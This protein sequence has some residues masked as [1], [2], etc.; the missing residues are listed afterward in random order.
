MHPTVSVTTDFDAVLRDR[1][2]DAVAVATPLATHYALARA[3]LQAGKHVLVEKTFTFSLE[4]AENLIRLARQKGRILM[5]GQTY[6][7]SP[8][9][10]KIKEMIDQAS[11]GKIH[12]INST[13]VHFGHL[14]PNESVIWDLASHDLSMVFFWLERYRYRVSCSGKDG[15]KRG[16]VDTADI[17]LEFLDGGPLVN[18]FVSWLAPIKMRN[19]IITG[20]KKMIFFNDTRNDEKLKV[21]DQRAVKKE[22]EWSTRAGHVHSPSLEVCEPLSAEIGD[23]LACISSGHEP[24]SSAAFNRHV[25]RALEAIDQ[26]LHEERKVTVRD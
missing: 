22:S 20:T 17:N 4:E 6:L 25:I 13:R 24:R 26:S 15:L 23:F 11:L 2:V 1:T 18:I 16:F 21:Y 14:R 7:Y 8:P 9:V 5:A 10:L 12:Y 19:M 3:A